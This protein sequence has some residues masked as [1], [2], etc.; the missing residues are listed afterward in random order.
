LQ[1]INTLTLNFYNF[2]RITDTGI[3]QVVKDISHLTNLTSLKLDLFSCKHL[4]DESII[5]I[6]SLVAKMP[7]IITL[8][9]NFYYCR[10]I[11]NTGLCKFRENLLSSNT[12]KH[13]TLSLDQT[14]VTHSEIE[15]TQNVLTMNKIYTKI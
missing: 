6:G 8:I 10:K 9:L 11:T 13:M 12:L 15:K 14:Q 5:H 3:I 4:T 1:T 2:E 7:R